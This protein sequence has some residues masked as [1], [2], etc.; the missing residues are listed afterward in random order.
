LQTKERALRHTDNLD[1]VSMY[2]EDQW[3]ALKNGYELNQLRTRIQDLQE[4]LKPRKLI[5][6]IDEQQSQVH[7]ERAG[8]DTPRIK[9]QIRLRCERAISE[10]VAVKSFHA[11]LCRETTEGDVILIEQETSQVVWAEPGMNMVSMDNGWTIDEPLSL[12]RWFIFFFDISN[13]LE[14]KLSREYFIRIT[15]TAVAQDAR[16]MDFYVDSWTYSNSP[17]TLR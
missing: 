1:L 14:A 9:A 13:R 16:S 5:F 7:L 17:I 2:S 11:A 3:T 10:S 4:A 12:Y 8:K 15:M 6:H